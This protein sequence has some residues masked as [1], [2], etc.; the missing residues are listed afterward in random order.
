MLEKL[1]HEIKSLIDSVDFSELW[2]GFYPMKFALYD[3]TDAFLTVSMWKKP[4]SFWQIRL[5]FTRANI[6]LS[7]T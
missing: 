1:F 7:G 4:I 2:R 5:F 3:E 6:S